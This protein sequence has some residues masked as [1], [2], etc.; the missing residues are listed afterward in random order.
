MLRH[1]LESVHVAIERSLVKFGQLYRHRTADFLRNCMSKIAA[2]F[3]EF[4]V[5]HYTLRQI[6]ADDIGIV[7][8]G[9]SDPEVIK[10]YALSYDSLEATK[11]QMQWFEQIVAE[12]QGIWWGIARADNNELVGACGFYDWDHTH[13]STELGYWLLPAYWGNGIMKASLPIIMRYA[14]DVMK[15]HRIHADVETENPASWQLLEKLGFTR[16]G[17]LRDVEC[18]DGRFLSLYKYSVLSTDA[19]VQGL[20]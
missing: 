9:L 12:D 11:V 7:Y 5:P 18:K 2:S 16:E 15:V 14:L 8:Q 6:Q 20:R 19:A 4:S 10:Y 13:R 3:P 17:M 1:V